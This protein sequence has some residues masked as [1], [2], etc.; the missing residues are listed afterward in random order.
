MTDHEKWRRFKKQSRC[1]AGLIKPSADTV[2]DFVRAGGDVE[3]PRCG[4]SYN[5][6]PE[7]KNEDAVG[8]VMTCEG[9][10]VTL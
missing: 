1:M 9:R 5:D 4:L 8:L 10:L 7:I 3:C 6:H 2:L